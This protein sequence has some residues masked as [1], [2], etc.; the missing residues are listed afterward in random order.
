M[1]NANFKASQIRY[2][3]PTARAAKRY[4]KPVYM[5]GSWPI[6]IDEATLSIRGY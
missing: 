4:L 3:A 5:I 6:L 1:S 2:L